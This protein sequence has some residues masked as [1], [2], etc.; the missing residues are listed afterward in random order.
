MSNCFYFVFTRPKVGQDQEFNNWYSK[1]HIYDLVAIPGIAAARRYRLLD[2]KTKTETPDYLAIYEFSDVD[3]AISGIAERRGTD[4]M[5]STEAI[6]RDASKGV[7]FKPL[8]DVTNE[9]RFGNGMLD[10]VKFDK[11]IDAVTLH[12]R[13]GLLVANHKQSRPGPPVFDVA[14]FVGD[15]SANGAA[16]ASPEKYH[17]RL[18]V[19]MSPI[20]ERVAASA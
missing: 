17:A 2:T 14:H 18:S 7:V 6:D 13:A 16:M 19:L 12:P 11:P 10:L 20:T 5:P 4:R 15:K 1:R 3:L 8:W 9:W